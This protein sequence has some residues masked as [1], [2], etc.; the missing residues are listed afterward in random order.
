[1]ALGSCWLLGSQASIGSLPVRSTI[2]H[3]ILALCLIP[4]IAFFPGNRRAGLWILGL[5]ALA[6]IFLAP[7]DP[8][9]DVHR[10]AWEGRVLQAGLNPYTMAPDHPELASIRD[11]HWDKINNKH[12]TAIYPPGSLLLFQA[13]AA[14][15]PDPGGYKLFLT[16]IDLFCIAIL[17]ALLRSYRRKPAWALLYAMNPVVL[18]AFAGEGHMDVLLV[19]FMLLAL[20]CYARKWFPA[21]FLCLALAIHAKYMA[22]LL[23]P[24]LINRSTCRSAWVLPVAVI[25]PT[26]AF[27]PFH[28]LF[29]SLTAFSTDMHYN[30]SIHAL[31]GRALGSFPFASQLAAVLLLGWLG[32]VFGMTRRPIEAGALAMSGLL[33]LAP[34][35]HF[36]YLTWVI[37][38]LCFYPLPPMLILCATIALM[39]Q[40]QGTMLQT[41][42]WKQYPGLV[43]LEYLPVYGALHYAAFRRRFVPRPVGDDAPRQQLY[44]LSVIVP[45]LNEEQMMPRLLGQMRRLN[46][47]AAEV[48]L[49]DGGSTD[50]TVSLATGAGFRVVHC[51]A[52]RG[53]Q[54]RA[55]I[56]A[57]SGDAILL[58]HAD[59]LIDPDTPE[60][61]LAALN[62]SGADGGCIGC[63]FENAN[64]FLHCI[65][66]LNTLR[67][68]VFGISFGDQGQFF[69]IDAL[70]S[71]GG[72][73]HLPIME[74]VE[75]S[76]RLK[77]RSRPVFLG[78]GLVV[79][80][81]GWQKRGN[82]RNTALVLR[83]CATY[84]WRRMLGRGGP[85][86]SDLY[87]AYYGSPAQPDQPPENGNA[88][89]ASGSELDAG[90]AAGVH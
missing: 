14:V 69:R 9:D 40:T 68:R 76:M 21:M 16:V 25:L 4:L 5:A 11:S 10:Y 33:L 37:P 66:L 55:G 41:G 7:M 31:L 50:Q 61:I 74:D 57:A 56:R 82:W 62:R 65:G 71:M 58:A 86:V 17:L 36:W 42:E 77:R 48:I 72:Y 63:R 6:R 49:C 51:P 19:F 90:S 80:S 44:N 38:F 88:T 18:L 73:P 27:W 34:T 89:R 24:F 79:S 53:T 64:L 84:S 23:I 20:L 1:M 59:M 81:R 39:F 67:A 35:V 46:G 2:L 54:N 52:G 75:L 8:A 47:F 26:L 87:A 29:T 32:F 28:G 83:L 85:D 22:V 15:T 60:R 30:G 70:D 45:V 12:M 3:V 13:L 78:G 43:L